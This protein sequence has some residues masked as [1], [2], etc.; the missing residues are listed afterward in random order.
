MKIGGHVSIAGGFDKSIDRAVDIGANILQ[1]F[2]SSPRSLKT[3]I[4]EDK[5]IEKYLIKKESSKMGDHFFHGVY[6]TA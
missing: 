3:K 5:I 1:T 4:F 2:A 6:L